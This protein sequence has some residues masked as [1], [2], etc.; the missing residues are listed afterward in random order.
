MRLTAAGV[1]GSKAPG[2]KDNLDWPVI[3]LGWR[4][5]ELSRPFDGPSLWFS[6][7]TA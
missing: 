7:H 2:R 5:V 1:A 3:L 6:A 4:A